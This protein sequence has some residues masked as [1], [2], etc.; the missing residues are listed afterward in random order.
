MRLKHQ[1]FI[2]TILLGFNVHSQ[3][4][5][6]FFS[7]TGDTVLYRYGGKASSLY[8]DTIEWNII[9]SS[10]HKN[11]Q[12]F[13]TV[14]YFTIRT[15]KQSQ[16]P[17]SSINKE[18]LTNYNLEYDGQPISPTDVE[19]ICKVDKIKI[20]GDTEDSI[21]HTYKARLSVSVIYNTKKIGKFKTYIIFKGRNKKDI[22]LENICETYVWKKKN[23]EKYFIRFEIK[24]FWCTNIL[25]NNCNPEVKHI[26]H[27]Y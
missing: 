19:K 5:R 24:S 16:T 2:L 23:K 22:D 13:N 9:V 11:Q 21:I 8:M 1:L 3:T 17:F 18:I 10:W 12:R 15:F 7:F 27:L 20:I 4:D 14:D 6:I 26:N 25:F